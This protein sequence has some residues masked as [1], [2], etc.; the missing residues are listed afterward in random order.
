MIEKGCFCFNDCVSVCNTCV[1]D[2]CYSTLFCWRS[3]CKR[4]HLCCRPRQTR[5]L[6][7]TSQMRIQNSKFKNENFEIQV[8]RK[9]PAFT[10]TGKT[11]QQ[12]QECVF[13]S[14]FERHRWEHTVQK[15]K[16]ILNKRDIK[17]HCHF[18]GTVMIDVIRN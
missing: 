16:L 10:V 2:L 15:D 12:V 5:W 3:R 14:I 13:K 11:K 17:R 1:I 8:K 6:L 18:S 4:H 7:R 9:R